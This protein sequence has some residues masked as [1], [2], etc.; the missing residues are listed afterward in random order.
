M[1]FGLSEAALSAGV[2][3]LLWA[4][5]VSSWVVIVYKT[6]WVWRAGQDMPVAQQAFWQSTDP[7]Q[8]CQ[9][10]TVLDRHAMLLPLAR[11]AYPTAQGEL[12]HVNLG[13]QAWADDFRSQRAVVQSLR[14][15]TQRVQWGQSWLVCVAAVAPFIGLLGTVWGLL[16]G[17][18]ALPVA[19]TQDWE[20]WLPALSQTLSLTATG[21]LVAV[22]ALLAHHLL[23]PRLTLLQQSLD[24]FAIDLIEQARQ[25]SSP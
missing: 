12:A 17:L 10:L 1:L 9:T 23:A 21:L 22:P 14:Q 15:V 11:Q 20:T 7:I 2:A 6:W 13:E 4:L 19:D 25:H 5:S 8:A 16:A 24:D 3:G 18:T